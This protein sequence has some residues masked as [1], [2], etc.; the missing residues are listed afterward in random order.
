MY[1]LLLCL[2]L[3]TDAVPGTPRVTNDFLGLPAGG[4]P[5]HDERVPREVRYGTPA[6]APASRITQ[7]PAKSRRADFPRRVT[8]ATTRRL[9]SFFLPRVRKQ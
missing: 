1:A 6:V 7:P 5:A 8:R 3:G 4:V 2:M 9:H